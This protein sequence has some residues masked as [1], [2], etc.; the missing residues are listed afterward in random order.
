VPVSRRQLNARR[1]LHRF[2]FGTQ[3]SVLH[4]V[5]ARVPLQISDYCTHKGS[6]PRK[7]PN[8]IQNVNKTGLVGVSRAV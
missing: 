2:A 1:S 6:Y 8:Q 5:L 3:I 7:K 4:C